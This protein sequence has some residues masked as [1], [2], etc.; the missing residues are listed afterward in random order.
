MSTCQVEIIHTTITRPWRDVYEFAR[1]PRNMA[2]WAAGLAAGLRQDGDEWI[3]DGGPLGDIRVRFTPPN[4]FGVIDHDVTL[5][6]GLTVHNALRVV[7]NG[8]GAEVMF[9]LIRQP[10]MDDAMFETDAAAVRR[11][12]AALKSLLEES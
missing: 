1:Q 10:E 2:R 5:P 3:G 12:L 8:S 7:P 6:G 11:D 4:G 9:T